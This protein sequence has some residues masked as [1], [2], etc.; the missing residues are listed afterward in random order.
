MVKN[1]KDFGTDFPDFNWVG[2]FDV[3]G[4]GTKI[5]DNVIDGEIVVE[6]QVPNSKKIILQTD[7][8]FLHVDEASGGGIIYYKTEKYAWVQQD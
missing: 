4:K 7:G 2:Q 6:E 3:V 8:I 1:G 5:W